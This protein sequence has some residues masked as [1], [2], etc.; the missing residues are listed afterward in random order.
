MKKILS[1]FLAIAMLIS[2]FPAVSAESEEVTITYTFT[3]V[4]KGVADD[5]LE[6][7]N[8]TNDGTI[9]T[10]FTNQTFSSAYETTEST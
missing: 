2:L 10:A 6:K 8:K 4:G 5:W 3:Q 1:L 9:A 7:I